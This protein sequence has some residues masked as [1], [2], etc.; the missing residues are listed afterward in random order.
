MNVAFQE[1][2]VASNT[3]MET[4]ISITESIQDTNKMLD[5]MFD[6][7]D[8]L[9]SKISHSLQTS[10]DGSATVSEMYNTINQ[11][12][13]GFAAVSSDLN[14]LTSVINEALEL[15]QL[16]QDIATQTNL[17][18]LNASIETARAG[19]SGRGFAVVA[20]EIRK[21][22]DMSGKSASQISE[23]LSEMN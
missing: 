12:N 7:M 14:R 18:S 23:K 21:L 19:E 11:F 15:N 8:Q 22:A 17:L 1:I 4:T 6:A 3:Q 20:N 13:E 2:A 5:Q 9:R 10:E 16:I